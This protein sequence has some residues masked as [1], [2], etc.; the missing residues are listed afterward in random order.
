MRNSSGSSTARGSGAHQR[1]G[2]SAEYQGKTPRRYAWISHSGVSAPPTASRPFG[3]MSAREVGGRAVGGSVF[4]SHAIPD[5]EV[6]PSRDVGA[7]EG[8]VQSGLLEP[9]KTRRALARE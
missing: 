1:I 6:E 5:I 3:S 2:C 4:C 9:G 7:P 8:Q